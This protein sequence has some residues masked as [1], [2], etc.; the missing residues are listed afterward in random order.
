MVLSTII[1]GALG[2]LIFFIIIISYVKLL[3]RNESG[4][5][6]LLMTFM[7][8][9]FLP[10]PI[11]IHYLMNNQTL[12]IGTVFGVLSILLLIITM[13]F[14]ASHLSFSARHSKENEKLWKENDLWMMQGLLGSQVELL[15]YVLKGIWIISLTI[16]FWISH[17]L[18]FAIL[19]TLYSFTTIVY[20][21]MLIDNSLLK[22]IALFKK[23]KFNFIIINLELLI[24][25]IIMLIWIIIQ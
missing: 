12:L 11:T 19:G 8:I 5:L 13:I 18:V 25:I 7:Y 6:H 4:F 9:C 15:A 14:Q 20:F 16:L 2:L 24:W 10:I 1:I 22:E 21:F 23:L 17:E 3:K